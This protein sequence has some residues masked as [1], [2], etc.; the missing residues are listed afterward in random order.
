MYIE[1]E[2]KAQ[3]YGCGVCES[4][5]PT[6]S[7]TMKTNEEGF[8]YP[9]VDL[10]TC[11]HCDKC[12]R[13]CPIDMQ[14]IP[15]KRGDLYAVQNKDQQV[16]AYSQSGGAFAALA[17]DI[18]NDGGAVYGAI[19]DA[20][21]RVKHV[22]ATTKDE[23]HPM[24]GSKYVQSIIGKDIYAALNVDLKQGRRVLFVGTPCQA[25]AV[26]K[27]YGK[28]ENLL[29]I[30]FACHG[31]PSP[32]LW[33]FFLG[34]KSGILNTSSKVMFRHVNPETAGNH[35]ERITTN[36]VEY[37]SNDY[38]ALFYSHLAHRP[39]CYA[40]QFAQEQRYADITI[41]GFLDKEWVSDALCGKLSMVF[42]NT[43]KGKTAYERIKECV[44]DE[45]IEEKPIILH[46][47]PC[48]YH[49]VQEPQNRALFW[50]DI[51]TKPFEYIVKKY[52]TS[53][54]ISKYKL[55][56]PINEQ[57]MD[58]VKQK[59]QAFYENDLKNNGGLIVHQMQELKTMMTYP[60]FTEPFRLN[61]LNALLSYAARNVPFYKPYFKDGKE[62]L[63]DF[64]ITNKPIL[65]DH[66]DALQSP[67]FIGAKGNCIQR[68]SG[69]TGVPS[70]IVWDYR[71]HMRLIADMKYYA[72]LAGVE[73]HERIVSM[74]A[75][76][77]MSNKTMADQERDNV[78][79]IYYSMLD[80][81]TLDTVIAE[82][83]TYRPKLIIG[84]GSMWD[85][86]AAWIAAGRA[87]KCEFQLTAICS[88]ADHLQKGTRDIIEGYFKCPMYSR[89]GNMECG[90]MAQEDS[91]GRGH[92]LNT[93]SYYWEVLKLDSDEPAAPGEVGRL[94][95][96]DLF[97]YA[98]PLIRYDNY[99]LGR[100]ET[101]EDGKQYLVEFMGRITD[102]LYTTKGQLV[103][104]HHVVCFSSLFPEIKRIQFIQEDAK[105]Y[106]CKLVTDNRSYEPQLIEE[107]KNAFGEDG[108]FIIEYVDDIPLLPNGKF[109]LT[110]CK[111]KKA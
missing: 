105:T 103:N 46:N 87:P 64:P 106:R 34:G 32:K 33:E 99:D 47:Q 93:A 108:T 81:D 54:I 80:F 8:R 31:V 94:V 53:E 21:F 91:T 75:F 57:R 98:M 111:Y 59:F 86:I 104:Q 20:D 89:Y 110:V 109:Q 107:F 60:K 15:C 35:A 62:K 77:K 82:A 76:R 40:C 83:L 72:A 4:A 49:P 50:D 6:K 23:L 25:A 71:K 16:L 73:S 88:E 42:V 18:I 74:H 2:N 101:M 44:R 39:S 17:Y 96:T 63:S 29:V 100:I 7:I 24:H 97:N 5:C 11:I 41:G 27:N 3:C 51:Q 90:V 37:L 66:H 12:V 84:Y 56:I 52:A 14:K 85:A 48:L 61:Y 67:E 26:Q 22:R 38:S 43:E 30:D 70:E 19:I 58:E 55:Q 78:Y 68:T 36:G 9:V 10:D 1:A 28:Y 92:L 13:V 102:A 95:L 65:R 79:N 69:S 45:Y